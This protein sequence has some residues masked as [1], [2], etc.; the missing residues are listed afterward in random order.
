VTALLSR[1]DRP[2]GPVL[3]LVVALVFYAVDG[4]IVRS[5]VFE[6][7]PDVIAAAASIDLTAGMTF[8][9]WLLVVR[10]GHAPLR[11]VIAVFLATLLGAALTMPSG[12]R[13][14]VAEARYLIL[15]AEIVTVGL[16]LVGIS[17]AR[18]RLRAGGIRLDVPE[19][20]RSLLDDT[21]IP[22]RVADVIATE[23][24]LVYYAFAAWRRSPFVPPD[25]TAFSYHRQNA[26]A[27][28]LWTLFAVSAVEL[29]VVHLLL[30][31][32]A[33]AIATIVLALSIFG[34]VWLLG[35]VRAVILRPIYVTADAVAIRSGV[36]WSVDIP[37][38]AIERV[39]IGRVAAPPKRTVNYLRAVPMGRPNVL[40]ALREPMPARGAYG[41]A[42]TVNTVSLVLDDPG[43]FQ[44]ALAPRG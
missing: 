27:A 43:A 23:L 30:R 32:T 26:Y 12:H 16:V 42:R 22:T 39:D 14:F 4:V 21:P 40:I 11:T 19:R 41:T 7:H 17:R 37:R 31:A 38:R 10:P 28:I 29:V 3:F 18:A 8:C 33:P 34:A 13:E 24:S 35:F 2:T 15:P 36:Q 5:P 9:Y 6:R 25:A 1:R 20:L 44:R